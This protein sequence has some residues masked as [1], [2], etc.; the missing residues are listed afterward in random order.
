MKSSF[1]SVNTDKLENK[2]INNTSKEMKDY[3]NIKKNINPGITDK[4]AA[5][6]GASSRMDE[7][8]DSQ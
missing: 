7:L 3:L 1:G 6:I 5:E 2:S 4:E 8:S